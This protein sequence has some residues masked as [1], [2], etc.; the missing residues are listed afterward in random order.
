MPTALAEPQRKTIE[1]LH[2]KRWTRKE[3]WELAKHV[4][5]SRYELING[6]LIDR[7]AKNAPHIR[8]VQFV[9]RCLRRVFGEEAVWQESTIDVRPDDNPTSDPEPDVVVL[10]GERPD[11]PAPEQVLLLVEVADTSLGLDLGEKRDLYARAG[12][13]DY[14][15][16]DLNQRR[17]IVHGDP[18]NGVYQK[19]EVY[20]EDE[21]IVP[22]AAPQA[23]IAVGEMLR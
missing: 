6:E 4:D 14:W 22:L 9:G 16:L 18:V 21:S 13:A 20:A 23:A 5:F 2:R 19:V 11:R 12:I 17:A 10:R 7:M 1:P 15:V 8:G 3:V